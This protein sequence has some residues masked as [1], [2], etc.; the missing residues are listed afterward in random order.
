VPLL[1]EDETFFVSP[2]HEG[3]N[4]PPAGKFYFPPTGDG[5]RSG[6]RHKVERQ[7]Y[8]LVLLWLCFL[9][10]CVVLVLKWRGVMLAAATDPATSPWFYLANF[11]AVGIILGAI[12]LAVARDRWGSHSERDRLRKILD[13]VLL[14]L[15]PL[16]QGDKERGEETIKA[17]A[18]LEVVVRDLTRLHDELERERTDLWRRRNG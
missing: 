9:S 2:L 15:L 10:L 8:A 12:L 16:I 4:E 3:T 14:D 5:S 11:G 13:S 7:G 1:Q 6:L 18:S 17:V